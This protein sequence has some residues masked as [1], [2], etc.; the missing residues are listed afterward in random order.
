MINNDV[1]R[2]NRAVYVH[3][4][5]CV[6]KHGNVNGARWYDHPSIDEAK[7]PEGLLEEVYWQKLHT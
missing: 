3:F 1:F 6:Q 5:G 7:L 4:P 2:D